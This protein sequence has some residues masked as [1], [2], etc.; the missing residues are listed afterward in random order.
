[1]AAFDVTTNRILDSVFA[2]AVWTGQGYE[3]IP[4][5]TVNLKTDQPGGSS[6][7]M[8]Q[9]L[10]GWQKTKGP[11][12][13]ESLTNW[14]FTLVP[15]EYHSS[16]AF[17]RKELD[18]DKFGSL[19]M[20]IAQLGASFGGFQAELVTNVLLTGHTSAQNCFDG[21]PFIGQS[22]VWPGSST[23][24]QSNDLSLNINAL[25]A[26]AVAG[27]GTVPSPEE[28]RNVLLRAGRSMLQ[29]KD[30]QGKWMH[31]S[32][33]AN[34]SVI[35]P[36]GLIEQMAKGVSLV[37]GQNVVPS[38]DMANVK[39]PMTFD[40]YGSPLLT[41]DAQFYM[42]RTDS[43]SKPL[44]FQTLEDVKTYTFEPFT[45]NMVGSYQFLATWIGNAGPWDWTKAARVTLTRS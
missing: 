43:P 1:M 30:S 3:W 22:H 20:Q 39:L 13:S 17:P 21:T 29:F 28:A 33:R 10:G 2:E 35:C 5:A 37:Q 15:E 18:Y 31:P 32:G 38:L 19:R 26:V 23:A 42:L 12:A 6:Y 7:G 34:F 24:A 41:N 44:A 16:V 8:T 27:T 9:S 25:G 14:R 11:I 4:S 36:M 45:V 40:I